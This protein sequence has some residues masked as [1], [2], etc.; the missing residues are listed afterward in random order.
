MSVTEIASAT[1][2]WSIKLRN[3][4]PQ[5]IL[6]DLGYFGHV[7]ILPG[8][9]DPDDY[10]DTLMDS[11]RYV[12]VS[13]GRSFGD[14]NKM[15]SGPGM[16]FWLGDEDGKGYTL[17]TVTA[18][19]NTT[20][21]ATLTA[22]LPDSLVV[23]NISALAG[24]F[25]NSFQYLSRRQAIDYVC[26]LYDAE[27]RIRGKG[28]FDAG[29]I[30]DL[31]VTDP[32]AAIIASREGMEMDYRALAGKAKLDADVRDFTTR[33]LLLATGADN[34]STVS[35]TADINPTLN[36]YVDL[37]GN[38]IV[39]T[40]IISET[41]TDEGNADARAQLQLNRFTSPKDSLNLSTSEYDIK[42]I[43]AA[44]DYVWVYDRE[45]LLV[46]N[47]NRI[48]F[49]GEEM[50][51]LKLR[52]F[53]TTWPITAD[54][55]VVFRTNDGRW[56][57]LSQWVEPETGDT[58]VVVGG[59][60]RS[61]TGQGAGPGDNPSNNPVPNTTIPDVISWNTP[62]LQATYQSPADGLTKAQIFLSWDQPLNT[63][64]SVIDDGLFYEIRW[65]T[66]QTGVYD[67]TH[68]DLHF[69]TH[70]QLLGTFGSPIPYNL[71]PWQ[72]TQISFD[73]L[74][75]LL[76]D[77]TPGIPYDIQIR[78]GDIAIP[79]NVGAWSSLV[80]VQTRPDTR[81]PSDPAPP[82]T[83]AGSR[84]AIQVVHTLGVA[85]G[86]EYNLEADLNHLKVHVGDT[87]DFFPVSEAISEGGTLAGKLLANRGMI[88]GNIPAVGTFQL[89]DEPGRAR[90]I[91]I[92]A[93]DNF[94]NESGPSQPVQQTAE[95]IDS[96]FISELTVSKV[97]A[98]T[99]NVDWLMAGE[100]A[101][102]LTGSRVN[103][104]WYGIEAWNI[105]NIRTFYLD[106]TTGQ[107]EI[108]GK[109]IAT[110]PI[111]NPGDSITI[112]PSQFAGSGYTYPTIE[113]ETSGTQGWGPAYINAIPGF[114]TN[115]TSLGL[116]SGPDGE[117][118]PN[119]QS[120][121]I[122]GASQWSIGVNSFKPIPNESRGGAAFGTAASAGLELNPTGSDI[123]GGYYV[124]TNTIEIQYNLAADSTLKC[125]ITMND[126]LIDLT[127]YGTENANNGNCGIEIQANGVKMYAAGQYVANTRFSGTDSRAIVETYRFCGFGEVAFR[128]QIDG[129]AG[130]VFKIRDDGTAN[131][132]LDGTGKGSVY[133]KNFVIDHPTQDDKWLVHACTESPT[134][135]VEYS[136][137]AVIKDYRAIVELPD[138]F[139]DLCLVEG[140][141]VLVTPMLPPDG[142]M[143]PYI[144]RAIGS[145]PTS[146]RFFISSDGLDGTLI[147]WRVFATRKDV[148]FPVEPLKNEFERVGDGPYTYLEAK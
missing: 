75:F 9:I 10:G 8:R 128:G 13:R 91:K 135:G 118:P 11:A 6:D 68:T 120:T 61:L 146:G 58:N 39:L 32:K 23:G 129:T 54:M 138:Y 125:D 55:G 70:N 24:L 104:G 57:D 59:Y 56:I 46:D 85:S 36:P 98:G 126:N 15:I 111:N 142:A 119:N 94:G 76:T 130:N 105:A 143:Y 63:D 19:T 87:A 49:H 123:R 132:I 4:C 116:N 16:A 81:A 17:E 28:V 99:I 93:V 48:D 95:L 72:S 92:T 26:S 80:T 45:A 106:A 50:Y 14:D 27:W 74:E 33:V 41:Q 131:L 38:P 34:V 137:T 101:T 60:N 127:R 31:Y 64:T 67:L 52:V 78:A 66:G 37:Y 90:Y 140:R 117:T 79:P 122:L 103:L 20:F 136:G 141:Q 97:S 144:P 100:I 42:G 44:G 3:D 109:F 77:L 88:A 115:G 147:A 65:R 47:A 96:A 145:V 108:I 86:G 69:Y 114:G 133:V 30:S 2:E 110:D 83:V 5:Y 84:N 82:Q 73:N 1:G 12:G 62:F 25:T 112:W 107:V 21:T 113:F 35:A 40:R 71:G 43:V 139:E 134:P 18:F 121:M 53:Q 102:A 148:S 29:L 22:L 7:C 51:P 124:F 89:D